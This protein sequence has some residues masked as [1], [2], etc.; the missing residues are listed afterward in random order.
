M[1]PEEEAVLAPEPR[2]RLGQLEDRAGRLGGPAA[3][4]RRRGRGAWPAEIDSAIETLYITVESLKPPKS[5]Y[6]RYD[7]L[8]PNDI[9]AIVNAAD[10]A[11]AALIPAE[12]YLSN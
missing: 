8:G 3:A 5:G 12:Q 6:R 7:D 9:A 4:R 11:R 2:G 1:A 10:S